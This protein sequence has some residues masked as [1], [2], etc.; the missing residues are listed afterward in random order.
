LEGT[1]KDNLV[2][3]PWPW[4]GTSCPRSRERTY[5]LKQWCIWFCSGRN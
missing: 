4:A 1:F 3:P 2:Q 5:T